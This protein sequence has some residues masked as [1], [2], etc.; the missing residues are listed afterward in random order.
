MKVTAPLLYSY[1]QYDTRRDITCA[2]FEIKGID[3]EGSKS[4][5]FMLKNAPFG[6]Y[7]GKWDVRKMSDEWLKQNLV[8]TAKHT[9][10]INP[11]KMRYSQ[12]LLYYAECMNELAGGPDATYPN[13][14]GL[15]ARQALAMVHSRAYDDSH[16]ADAEAYV[17]SI[18]GDKESFFNAL[19]DE[20][21]WE[22]A[23]EGIRKFDLIRWNLLA[24]KI[25]QFKQDYLRELQ[26]GTYQKMIYFNYSDAAKTK[27]D[28]SS[29]TWN[30]LPAGVSSTEYQDSIASFGDSK[31][32]S[33][34]DTQVDVN[35]PSISSGLVGT[36]VNV[37]GEGVPVKNRYLMPIASTT[38]S[39]SNG[40]LHNSYGYKD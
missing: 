3:G 7:V 33:G 4:K 36:N 37:I 14:A 11:V 27:I 21:A 39:A 6:I 18:P 34:D 16:K 9:T 25:Y 32:D 29:V 5:E 23:G 26:D 38:I 8:A 2:N 15:T 19:V 40:R 35:L 28:M 17:S 24:E 1:K 20:N 30:G 12:V 31:I 13:S 22:F 10:G